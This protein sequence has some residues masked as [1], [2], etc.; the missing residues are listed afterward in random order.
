MKM[1]SP[2][3]INLFGIPVEAMGMEEALDTVHHAISQHEQLQIGVVNAA[4]VVN[5]HRDPALRKD[6][7]SSDIIFAD[8]AAVVLASKILGQSLPER[9]TGIDLM[10]GMFERGKEHGYRVYCLGA[11]EEVSKKVEENIAHDYPGLILAGRHH[12]Y[13][14]EDE[15]QSIADDIKN[16]KADILLVAMTSPK[17]EQFLAKWMDYMG[18]SVCHG[19]GGSFDVYSG[20]VERAPERWQKLGLEWLYRVKQEPGRLWKR[21]LFT[22]LAFIGLLVKEKLGLLK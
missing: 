10:F 20:K 7:L 12:G 1:T 13:Y 19:V 17:K 5:M 15:Q 4:K 22:N 11:T 6:V 2:A 9:V 14:S 18:V 8:G 3:K 16:S 21:Y